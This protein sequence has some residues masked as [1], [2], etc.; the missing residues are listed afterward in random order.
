MVEAERNQKI[1]ELIRQ[2]N[3]QGHLTYANINDALPESIFSDEYI[4]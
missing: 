3:D 1:K 4:D 2:A